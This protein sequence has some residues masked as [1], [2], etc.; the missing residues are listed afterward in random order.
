MDHPSVRQHKWDHT[1]FGFLYRAV[2]GSLRNLMRGRMPVRAV[3]KN[4]G[5]AFRLPLVHLGLATDFWREFDDRYLKLEKGLPSTFFVIPFRDH[6]GK[7]ATGQGLNSAPLNTPPKISRMR[8]T[9]C[10]TQAAK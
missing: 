7:N 3:V 6:A 9:S 10:K 1:T 4:W 5:A 2:F 8:S